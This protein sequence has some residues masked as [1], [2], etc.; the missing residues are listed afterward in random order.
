MFLCQ[1]FSETLTLKFDVKITWNSFTVSQ[2]KPARLDV[3]SLGCPIM[4]FVCV[5]VCFIYSVLSFRG[6]SREVCV[7]IKCNF[8][9]VKSVC[10]FVSMKC[11]YLFHEK[12][13][14]DKTERHMQCF[15]SVGEQ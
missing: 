6:R 9:F 5:F 14:E 8:V 13:V 12:F 11:V 10:N 7:F 1:H 15:C 3:C 4:F 2:L